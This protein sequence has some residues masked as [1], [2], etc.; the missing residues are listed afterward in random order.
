MSV[1]SV[2]VTC[3]G[4]SR[5]VSSQV[6]IQLVSGLWSLDRSSLFTSRSSASRTWSGTSA[7]STRAR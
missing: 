7:A 6:R 3:Q 4:S 2:V 5:T 1:E